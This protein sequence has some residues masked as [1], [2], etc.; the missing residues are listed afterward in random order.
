LYVFIH[1]FLSFVGM[2]VLAALHFRGLKSR[3][4]LT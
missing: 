1:P 3:E 2:I 4:A